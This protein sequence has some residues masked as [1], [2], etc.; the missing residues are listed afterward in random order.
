LNADT[1]VNNG[2]NYRSYLYIRLHNHHFHLQCNRTHQQRPH[3][4]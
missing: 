1:I 2:M 3:H 4:Q